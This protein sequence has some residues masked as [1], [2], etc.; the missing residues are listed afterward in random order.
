[1]WFRQK[2]QTMSWQDQLKTEMTL[3]KTIKVAAAIIVK[4]DLY[5]VSQRQASQHLAGKWEFPGGK[6]ELG[7]TTGQAL[8]REIKEE[9]GIEVIEQSFFHSLSFEYPETQVELY[10]QLVTSFKGEPQGVEGQKIQWVDLPS[11][12]TLDF[13]E[14]N[15]PILAMLNL[16]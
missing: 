3:K 2:I 16:A 12:L 11:L 6:I 5:L 14:A 9:L 15:K 10:F 7:E 4:D 13:P 8:V 1:M